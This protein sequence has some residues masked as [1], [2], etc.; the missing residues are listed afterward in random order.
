VV[1]DVRNYNERS[2]GGPRGSD[3]VRDEIRGGGP[4]DPVG[5]GW[6]HDNNRDR[7]HQRGVGQ[8]PMGRVPPPPRVHPNP[9][10]PRTGPPSPS[11]GDHPPTRPSASAGGSH[12]DTPPTLSLPP[13]S[14]GT[15]ATATSEEPSASTTSLQQSSE[16]NRPNPCGEAIPPRSL[17]TCPDT[18]VAQQP[19]ERT[20][21]ASL[22][23]KTN[24]FGDAKPRDERAVLEA[25][26]ARKKERETKAGETEEREREAMKLLETVKVSRTMR[27]R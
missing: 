22:G 23:S 19:P 1:G 5:N 27:I 17:P 20:T 3:D 11:G 16:S 9:L 18:P 24:P 14:P 13:H 4:L 8:D 15:A 12:D 7:R 10:S 2:G 25:I 6:R 26:E 21:T